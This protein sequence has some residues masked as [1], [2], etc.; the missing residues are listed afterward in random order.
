M[1]TSALYRRNQARLGAAHRRWANEDRKKAY[2]R[3]R[4]KAKREEWITELILIGVV[5]VG[6]AVLMFL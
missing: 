1:A 2:Y 6:V 3:T 4:R 5:F